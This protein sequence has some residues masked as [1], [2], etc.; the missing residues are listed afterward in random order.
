MYRFKILIRWSHRGMNF[1][2]DIACLY[3]HLFRIKASYPS[4]N[5]YGR[6]LS[7]SSRTVHLLPRS[8][9]SYILVCIIMLILDIKYAQHWKWNLRRETGQILDQKITTS[10]GNWFHLY[11]HTGVL[12]RTGIPGICFCPNFTTSLTDMIGFCLLVE[13]T[14]PRNSKSPIS[15]SWTI[16]LSLTDYDKDDDVKTM[17]NIIVKVLYVPKTEHYH[18]T[19]WMM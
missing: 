4:I 13:V 16:Y 3:L 2:V 19:I 9:S 15:T 11:Q 1:E 10:V 14:L 18:I 6:R 17:S 8:F 12:D 5:R 7:K